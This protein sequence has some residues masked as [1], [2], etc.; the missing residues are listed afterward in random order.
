MGKMHGIL[1]AYFFSHV[2]QGML[3]ALL[4][5]LFPFLFD[6]RALDP[7]A[8]RPNALTTIYGSYNV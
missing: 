4:F 1:S 3:A 6:W 2:K 7:I 8:R 5:F